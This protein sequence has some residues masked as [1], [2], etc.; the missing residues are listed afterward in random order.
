MLKGIIATDGD[1]DFL[2]CLLVFIRP[3]VSCLYRSS[4]RSVRIEIFF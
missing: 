4:V 2:S 3:I 1:I